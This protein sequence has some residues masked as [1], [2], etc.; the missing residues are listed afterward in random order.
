MALQSRSTKPFGRFSRV[1]CSAFSA[2]GENTNAILCLRVAM[3]GGESEPTA[4]LLEV[5]R[6]AFTIGISEPELA[7]CFHVSGLSSFDKLRKGRVAIL[8]D[9]A[10]EKSHSKR[11]QN[12][13]GNR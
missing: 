4:R 10:I 6:C 7:L 11:S 2:V 9:E 12:T 3:L 1:L 8:G 5:L 13:C